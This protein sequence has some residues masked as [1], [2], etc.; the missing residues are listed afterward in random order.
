MVLSSMTETTANLA[1]MSALH[2]YPAIAHKL[3]FDIWLLTQKLNRYQLEISHIAEG[4]LN[5]IPVWPST[6]CAAIWL[7]AM[8]GKKV[9]LREDKVSCIFLKSNILY[10]ILELF[11]SSENSGGQRFSC[12]SRRTLSFFWPQRKQICVSDWREKVLKY[13]ARCKAQTGSCQENHV[14]NKKIRN[15]IRGIFSFR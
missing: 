1:W 4:D 5:V 9:Q 15:C 14:K 6:P 11:A 13:M 7:V 2:I 10:V 8:H 12:L 3:T